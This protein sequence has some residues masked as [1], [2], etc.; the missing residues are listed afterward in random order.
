M[1]SAVLSLWIVVLASCSIFVAFKY[2]Y[3]SDLIFRLEK[4]KAEINSRKS[5][6]DEWEKD[7]TAREGE[8]RKDFEVT[9][10]GSDAIPP[11]DDK[12][13]KVIIPPKP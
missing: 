12:P 7:L 13:R 3:V 1:T 4:D 11:P 10:S 6:L 9:T 2:S 8:W 5:E